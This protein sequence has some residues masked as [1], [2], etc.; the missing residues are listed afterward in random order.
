MVSCLAVGRSS[1][2]GENP[3]VPYSAPAIARI[4]GR[5]TP[6]A[7]YFYVKQKH[8]QIQD[9]KREDESVK[10]R[11]Q[12]QQFASPPRYILGTPEYVTSSIWGGAA[13]RHRRPRGEAHKPD[14]RY[15]E[16][17]GVSATAFLGRYTEKKKW[18]STSR[19]AQIG[20]LTRKN[21]TKYFEVHTF[22]KAKECIHECVCRLEK[23]LGT[24]SLYLSLSLSSS[25]SPASLR[26]NAPRNKAEK[27]RRRIGRR[28]ICFFFINGRS[29]RDPCKKIRVTYFRSTYSTNL[30]R[31]DSSP[32]RELNVVSFPGEISWNKLQLGLCVAGQQRKSGDG[33]SGDGGGAGERKPRGE[34]ASPPPAACRTVVRHRHLC[35]K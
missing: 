3:S 33:G 20:S 34:G 23:T 21:E 24:L 17:N 19:H 10:D 29:F 9:E 12:L 15:G 32:S 31:P 1:P 27:H 7:A 2:G 14:I 5:P 18:A 28:V 4:C 35:C 8:M 30:S 13:V 11:P 6:S 26:S 22:R 25:F 16:W